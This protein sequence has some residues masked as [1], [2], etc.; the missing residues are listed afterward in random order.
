MTY[1]LDALCERLTRRAEPPTFFQTTSQEEDAMPTPTRIYVVAQKASEAPAPRRLV[2]AQ[3]PA[4]ALRHVVDDT[5]IVAI[6]SQDDLVACVA[7]GVKV[8]DAKGAE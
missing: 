3:T 4:A 1:W 8:E 6:A 2:R 5:L 7:A